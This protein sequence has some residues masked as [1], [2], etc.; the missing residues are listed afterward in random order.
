MHRIF[1]NLQRESLNG[2]QIKEP[3]YP[4]EGVL[5][6]ERPARGSPATQEALTI[7]SMALTCFPSTHK[8]LISHPLPLLRLPSLHVSDGTESL[9]RR[10]LT[11]I[12][13]E[14]QTPHF[15]N[16]SIY[17]IAVCHW[18]IPHSPSLLGKNSRFLCQCED[19]V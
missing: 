7:L 13:S 18:D 12:W 19:S 5:W 3:V 1:L 14:P 17:E 15:P 6:R 16:A 4:S 9:T 10:M 8:G 11:I 2:G